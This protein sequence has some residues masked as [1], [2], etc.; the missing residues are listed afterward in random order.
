LQSLELGFRAHTSLELGIF[1]NLP[2]RGGGDI[3]GV[4]VCVILLPYGGFNA[5]EAIS[6]VVGVGAGAVRLV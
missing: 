6:H 2:E 1:D 4:V 5:F 3:G